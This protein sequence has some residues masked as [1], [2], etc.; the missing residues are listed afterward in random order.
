MELCN[1]KSRISFGSL[2]F[3]EKVSITKESPVEG[4]S[5]CDQFR[6]LVL[7]EKS[8]FPLRRK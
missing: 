1:E 8:F 6:V 5:H 7:K 4:G 2:Q 3:W